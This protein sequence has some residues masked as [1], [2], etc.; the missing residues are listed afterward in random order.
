MRWAGAAVAATS[1][2]QGDNPSGA[3]AA[4]MSAA[5]ALPIAITPLRSGAAETGELG[6]SLLAYRER[7]PRMKI[8]EPVL[9]ASVPFAGTWELSASAL[10]DI[11]TG[12]SPGIVTNAGGSPVQTITGASVADHRRAGEARLAKRLG[13]LTV[14]VSRTVSS[15]EDYRSRAFG[16]DAKLDLAGRNTTLV[17]GYGKSGDRIGSVD[18]PQLD[19]HRDTREYLVGLT[20]VLSPHA[21]VQSNVQWSRGK[22]WYSDPYLSTVT[23]YPGTPLPALMLDTRP[24]FRNSVAWLT[25]YRRHFPDRHATFQADYR[26]FRDDWGIR[27]HALEIAWSRDLRDGWAARAAL[28]W[29]S[30]SAADFYAALVPRPRPALLS[31]DQRLAAFGSLSPSMRLSWRSAEGIAVEGTVGFY[32][33]AKG[34]RI[35]GA[36]SPEFETLSATYVLLSASREF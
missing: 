6:I 8:T 33:N 23:F 18:D 24:D 17:A 5:L 2:A 26:H 15:E 10:V 28:R 35:G 3:L 7:G 36:G 27:S 13:E 25:R 29:Y 21:I 1:G 20:Q 14:S 12:A 4:L 30:Q 34:Y 32:R 19:E 31:S 16:I 11:V 22:G 9:W